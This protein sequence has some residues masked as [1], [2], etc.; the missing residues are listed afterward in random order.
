MSSFEPIPA[1]TSLAAGFC[2]RSVRGDSSLG[3]TETDTTPVFIHS[4][5]CIAFARLTEEAEL[6]TQIKKL[7]RLRDQIKTW[8]ASNEI[9]DK[10]ALTDNR[11]LIELVS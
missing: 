1:T 2:S 7:Q 10:K 5:I 3:R 9:K 6:K 8:L 11:K 4:R